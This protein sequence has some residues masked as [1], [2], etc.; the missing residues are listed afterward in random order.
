MWKSLIGATALF[1]CIAGTSSAAVIANISDVGNDIVLTYSGSVNLDSTLRIDAE[2]ANQERVEIFT[3]PD[4]FSFR[5]MNGT[6]VTD[7]V[8][9]ITSAPSQQDFLETRLNTDAVSGDSFLFQAFDPLFNQI[10]LPQGYVSGQSISGTATFA[11][12]SLADVGA[13]FGSYRWEWENNGV[14]DSLTV[15]VNSVSAVPVP[16]ALPLLATALGG[17]GFLSWRRRWKTA[18]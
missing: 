3:S 16:A 6:T 2:R 7:Y 18:A 15:N 4:N 5:A 8:I 13:V 12:N 10:W 1:G 17:L 9:D 14:S 11:N